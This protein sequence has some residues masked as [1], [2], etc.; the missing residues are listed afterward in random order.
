MITLPIYTLLNT[1]AALIASIAVI[2]VYRKAFYLK[3]YKAFF[4]WSLQLA[5]IILSSFITSVIV[6]IFTEVKLFVG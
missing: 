6:N 1:W 2:A 5:F 4:V 3:W